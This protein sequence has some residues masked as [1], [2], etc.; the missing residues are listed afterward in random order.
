MQAGVDQKV[1]DD[2]GLILVRQTQDQFEAHGELNACCAS[3]KLPGSLD[4][5]RGITAV[6]ARKCLRENVFEFMSISYPILAPRLRIVEAAKL[7]RTVNGELIVSATIVTCA[8]SDP[9]PCSL[10]SG[11]RSQWLANGAGESSDTTRPSFR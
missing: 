5:S 3:C 8:F 11:S 10:N 6:S 9:T 4:Q 1:L 2:A 7:K